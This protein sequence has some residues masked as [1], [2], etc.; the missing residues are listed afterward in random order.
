MKP[1]TDNPQPS[2]AELRALA[3][4]LEKKAWSQSGVEL[5]KSLG[6]TPDGWQMDLLRSQARRLL[7]CC[8]R[9]SGKSTTTAILSLHHAL[10][11]P[12]G[13]PTLT[14]LLSPSQ[15]QSSELF[16]KVLTYYRQL[17]R[18]EPSIEENKLSL[19]LSNGSRIISLPSSE[20]T[21]RG[22]SGVTLLVV[23]EAARVPDE[24]YRSVRPM[25]ATS[26]GRLVCLSTPFG[27][28]GFFHE[29]WMSERVWERIRIP[30]EM[31]PRIPAD[32]LAE[33]RLSLG[34]MYFR[35]EYGCEFSAMAGLVYPS[36]ESCISD[37]PSPWP[38]G[39]YFAG[40]DWGFHNPACVLVGMKTR[41]DVLWLLQEV[42]GSGM[43]N[44]DLTRRACALAD[45]YPIELIWCDPAE[46]GSIDMFRRN[47]LPAT[48]GMNRI[49]PGIQAVTA[50]MNTGRLKTSR[51]CKNLIRE[52]GLY[53]Y[54]T[55]EE[56][57]IVGENPI[58]EHNHALAALRYM[59]AGIDR[60][61]ELGARA[62]QVIPPDPP[63]PPDLERDYTQAPPQQRYRTRTVEEQFDHSDEARR[64]QRQHLDENG[65]D[66]FGGAVQ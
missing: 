47:N 30:A 34:E 43:T 61:R 24:L 13:K 64:M 54:P 12:A 17:S 48:E 8:S 33:E 58:D 46:P 63:P 36:L 44:E 6:M 25:L 41:D 65:W 9:Q 22:Y 57:K 52:A 62:P 18:P 5:M 19:E 59:V 11:P 53:R 28:R 50:R 23:D 45:T 35:Q 3:A 29:E 26:A 55:P 14:L 21:I 2:P 20:E 51:A 16:R 4:R 39:R 27:K 37:L 7:L 32:F 56:R 42:Y 15:R 40:V 1:A 49:L 31:C 60:V 38:E 66:G 10:Y